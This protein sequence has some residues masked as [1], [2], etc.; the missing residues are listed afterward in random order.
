V[1]LIFCNLKNSRGEISGEVADITSFIMR[2]TQRRRMKAFRYG[3]L[4]NEENLDLITYLNDGVQPK[5]TKDERYFI[6][7]VSNGG[8]AIE[9]RMI[10]K[11]D[12]LYNDKGF[13]ADGYIDLNLMF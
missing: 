5:I 6:F 1:A 10:R 11:E 2:P 7:R 13:Y 4:I 8:T 3:I 12:T 9:S